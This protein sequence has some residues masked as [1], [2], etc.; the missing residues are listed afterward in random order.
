MIDSRIPLMGQAPDFSQ[1]PQQI[2][3]TAAG[4][5]QYR[6]QQ[7]EAPIRQALLQNQVDQI[8]LQNQQ[9]QGAVDLQKAQLDSLKETDAFKSTVYGAAQGK[10]L[11]DA[12]DVN[13]FL[14]LADERAAN[15]AQRGG[16]ADA[17]AQIAQMVRAGDIEGAKQR[18]ANG[19]QMGVQAGILMADGRPET[20]TSFNDAKALL[21]ARGITPGSPGYDK[22]LEGA[23]ATV[24]DPTGTD[25]AR[26]DIARQGLEVD[27]ARLNQGTEGGGT[28]KQATEL[29]KEFINASKDY[30]LQNDAIGRISASAKDPSAAGD[31]SL[32]FSYMKMLDPGSTVR[33]GEFATA[34]NA[35]SVPDRA[36]AAYNKVLSG[37]RLAPAQRADFVQQANKIYKQSKTQH[38]KRENEYSRLA[39]QNDI[40]PANVVVDFSTYQPEAAAPVAGQAASQGDI[41]IN[42][43]TIKRVR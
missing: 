12:G 41:V 23:L 4:I 35:G 40:D 2:L 28:F 11:L 18:L 1:I 14:A 30:A 16:N 10:Q 34:Q 31:L 8:P 25:R 22:A 26:I 43:V 21:A 5:N 6:Q 38:A 9:A 32:I 39:K 13:G 7:A 36:T 33:E 19:V 3:Q 37:E 20:S 29:R 27:R 15:V 42:G 24:S 17:T